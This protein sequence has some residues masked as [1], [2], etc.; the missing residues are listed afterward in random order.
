MRKLGI[1]ETN[2]FGLFVFLSTFLPSVT[3][4]VLLALLLLVLAFAFI[5]ALLVAI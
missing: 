5:F 2:R 4:V 3:T 1:P